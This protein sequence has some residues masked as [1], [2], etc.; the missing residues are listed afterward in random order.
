MKVRIYYDENHTPMSFTELHEEL[1]DANYYEACEKFLQTYEATDLV[2]AL[3]SANAPCV[4]PLITLEDFNEFLEDYIT[5]IIEREYDEKII[6]I[7]DE[8]RVD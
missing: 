1:I 2:E 4:K 8:D 3:V 7:N 6:E 5:D